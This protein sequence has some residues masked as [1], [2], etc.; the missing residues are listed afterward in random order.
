M[1]TPLGIRLL[2]L[3]LHF[4]HPV[5]QAAMV[6]PRVPTPVAA[7][8]V[9]RLKV[10]ARG[11]ASL[12][13]SRQTQRL[14]APLAEEVHGGDDRHRPG[15]GSRRRQRAQSAPPSRAMRHGAARAARA[16]PRG[17]Q[18]GLRDAPTALRHRAWSQRG[19]HLSTAVL[20][21]E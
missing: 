1:P 16:P 19:K 10:V 14:A 7:A 8:S 15:S 5:V 9:A 17:M 20:A 13:Q 4:Y 3:F 6:V 2:Y 12:E 21:N 18:G 11:A